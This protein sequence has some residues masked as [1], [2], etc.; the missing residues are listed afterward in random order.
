MFI[1]HSNEKLTLK[2]TIT[3]KKHLFKA[4]IVK[5][6]LI[7]QIFFK[8]LHV[9]KVYYEQYQTPYY[10]EVLHRLINLSLSTTSILLTLV[11]SKQWTYNSYKSKKR[12]CLSHKNKK[13]EIIIIIISSNL[14]FPLHLKNLQRMGLFVNIYIC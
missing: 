4:L 8:G 1:L 2:N 9:V 11:L 7:G 5:I 6:F 3:R 13:L 12:R 14:I 10:L